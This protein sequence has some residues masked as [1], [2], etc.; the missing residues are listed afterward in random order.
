MGAVALV[1]LVAAGCGERRESSPPP[2]AQDAATQE[3]RKDVSEAERAQI[4]QVL[5]AR[6]VQPGESLAVR[7]LGTIGP[8]GSWALDAVDVRREPE[9]VVLVPRVRRVPGDA[10][11]QMVMPLDRTL[12]LELPAGKHR[13]EVQGR[14]SVH[15][16]L[17]EV[18]PGAV[19]PP[20]EIDIQPRAAVDAGADAMVPVRIEARV[21]DGFVDR[22]ELRETSGGTTTAWRAPEMVERLGSALAATTTLRRPSGDLA[23][24]VE[25]RAVDGQGTEASTSITLPAR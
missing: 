3:V 4:E 11:I 14:D 8:D 23:R 25:A 21:A 16:A 10:F 19:R 12:R 18:S 13:I 9:R 20:V 7:L 22:I 1:G 15:T 24:K 6:A 5:V 2:A 17:V